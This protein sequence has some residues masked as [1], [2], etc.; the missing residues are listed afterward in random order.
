MYLDWYKIIKAVKE[1]GNCCL[2]CLQNDFERENNSCS[3]EDFRKMLRGTLEA[4]HLALGY[5]LRKIGCSLTDIVYTEDEDH[6]LP[7]ELKKIAREYNIILRRDL[8][9]GERNTAY[10]AG[11]EIFL[12]QFDDSDNERFAFFHELAH[13]IGRELLAK[14]LGTDKQPVYSLS[15]ISLEG[16]CW[17]VALSIAEKYGYDYKWLC[18]EHIYA[19]NQYAT[20]ITDEH[21]KE[22]RKEI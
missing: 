20:Y 21:I 8:E 16:F 6:V 9:N 11:D 18:K 12:N 17:E 13:C 3:L 4:D 22:V 19:L 5:I 10:S 7:E 14:A 15:K 2:N 1:N